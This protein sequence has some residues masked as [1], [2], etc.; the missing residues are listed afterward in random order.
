MARPALSKHL[1]RAGIG[2][3]GLAG[4]AMQKN[5]REAGS[6]RLAKQIDREKFTETADSH[7]GE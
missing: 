6:R 2:T 4:E 5:G 1:A 3:A 7:C